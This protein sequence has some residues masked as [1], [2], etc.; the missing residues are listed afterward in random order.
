M[1]FRK[2][3]ISPRHSPLMNKLHVIRLM[4]TSIVSSTANCVQMGASSYHFQNRL[5]I[6]QKLLDR[7]HAPRDVHARVFIYWADDVWSSVFG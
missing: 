1:G 5:D 7:V 6:D 4:F 3:T 2:G